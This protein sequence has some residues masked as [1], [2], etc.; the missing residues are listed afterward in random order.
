MRYRFTGPVPMDFP[1][2]GVTLGPGDEIDSEEPL[3]SAY[4]QP[5][6]VEKVKEAAQA[7]PQ[8]AEGAK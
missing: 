2:L 6:K 4:L 1:G 8:T 5:V 3:S 7:A